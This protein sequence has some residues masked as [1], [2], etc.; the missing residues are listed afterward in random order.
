MPALS[1]GNAS[2]ELPRMRS[3]ASEFSAAELEIVRQLV[4][5]TISE[6]ERELIRATLVYHGGNR[7]RVAR[8]LDIS[9]RSL[10]NKIHEYIACGITVPQPGQSQS[11][12]C[13]SVE[14]GSKSF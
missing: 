3:I 13:G 10:R 5:H 4:G 11:R 8:V 1:L 12:G 9:I 14:D 6:V 2:K 7:T